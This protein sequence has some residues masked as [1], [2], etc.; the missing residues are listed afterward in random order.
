MSNTGDSKAMI[1]ATARDLTDQRLAAQE[2]CLANGVF[3][4]WMQHLP[5]QDR[6]GFKVSME[7][8]DK[9]DIYIGIYAWRYGWVPDFD[10]PK[11]VS[12]TELEFDRAVGRK[13]AGKLKELLIFIMDESVKVSPADIEMSDIAQQKLKAFKERASKK[14]VVGFFKSTEDLQRQISEA[15]AAFNLRNLAKPD[16]ESFE[17]HSVEIA[18]IPKPP[19]RQVQIN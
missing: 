18:R 11:Q 8:V 4:V 5:A 9:A 6:D 1:S 12:I 14:R 19:F 13:A 17:I 15:L 10:N 7:M 16:P 3:P 2:A